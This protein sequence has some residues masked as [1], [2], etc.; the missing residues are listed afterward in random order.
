MSTASLSV[1]SNSDCT[2]TKPVNRLGPVITFCAAVG[3]IVICGAL[4]WA[5]VTSLITTEASKSSETVI[6]F[7]MFKPWQVGEDRVERIWRREGLKVPQA[8]AGG[9]L[10]AQRRVVRLPPQ[11]TNHVWNYDFVS[12]KTHDG[13][14]VRMLNLIDEQPGRR[15]RVLRLLAEHEAYNSSGFI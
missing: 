11:H 14:T 8:K 1:G 4:V 9:A 5:A 7:R 6:A 10:V 2:R 12:A 3:V 13:R 15:G